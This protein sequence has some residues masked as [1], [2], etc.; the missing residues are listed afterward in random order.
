M[1]VRIN[2]PKAPSSE[3]KVTLDG[4]DFYLRLRWNTRSGWFFDLA[5][6]DNVPIVSNRRLVLNWPLLATVTD[7]RRPP[8]FLMAWDPS[9]GSGIGY[10][11]LGERVSLIYKPEAEL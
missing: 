10:D 3:T 7:N 4:G 9:N 6:Q 8:G 2:V 11:D 5:D 1:T